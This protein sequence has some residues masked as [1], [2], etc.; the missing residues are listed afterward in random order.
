M[1]SNTTWYQAPELILHPRHY[2]QAIDV[3]AAGCVIA[4]MYLGK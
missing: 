1:A 2:D 4:G 3:W